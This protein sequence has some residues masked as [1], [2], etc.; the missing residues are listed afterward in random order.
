MSARILKGGLV[1]VG[2][3]RATIDVAGS[4]IATDQRTG[5]GLGFDN[6]AYLQLA[7]DDAQLSLQ[8]GGDVNLRGVSSMLGVTSLPLW[9]S[10][11]YG[12]SGNQP[13]WLGYTADT[14]LRVTSLGGDTQLSNPAGRQRR[15]EC[16]AQPD[17][18]RRDCRF[19]QL[20][21]GGKRRRPRRRRHAGPT[22]GST[23][24]RSRISSSAS[25]AITTARASPSA[26]PTRSGV[27][28]AINP[29][30]SNFNTPMF[31]S[32]ITQ[33]P[34]NGHWM[35]NQAGPGYGDRRA[36]C[37]QRFVELQPHL[38]RAGR[39][40]RLERAAATTSIR[41]AATGCTAGP[42]PS[43]TRRG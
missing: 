37:P 20:R 41:P 42:S 25:R 5:I 19:D 33:D 40:D 30:T 34:L 3:G 38:R 35:F 6:A 14:G 4:V 28:R 2:K 15:G 24:S 8:A 29:G 39:H 26:T 18:V 11:R 32:T 17:R 16:S 36:Q 7:I 22:R 31:Q 10:G 13:S 9:L 1:Q 23:S 43:G 27:P 21:D 12:S